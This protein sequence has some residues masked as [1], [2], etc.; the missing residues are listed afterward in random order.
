MN[1]YDCL[2]KEFLL[3]LFVWIVFIYCLNLIDYLFDDFK[4]IE[5]SRSLFD[6][7]QKMIYVIKVLI[8]N[9]N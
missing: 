1:V 8:V 3:D 7:Y 9:G 5:C 2:I 4:L 6:L